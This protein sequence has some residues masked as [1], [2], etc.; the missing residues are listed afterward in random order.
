MISR[1]FLN[2]NEA[3]SSGFGAPSSPSQLSDLHFTRVIGSLGGSLA[4]GMG[5]T[6]TSDDTTSTEGG[7]YMDEGLGEESYFLPSIG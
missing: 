2:L 1:F 4:Y 6:E 7:I 5:D 3:N